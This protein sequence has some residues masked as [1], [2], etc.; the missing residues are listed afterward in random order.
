MAAGD[1]EMKKKGQVH[2]YDGVEARRS[3]PSGHVGREKAPK[4]QALDSL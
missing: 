2:V 1:E 4:W 3:E